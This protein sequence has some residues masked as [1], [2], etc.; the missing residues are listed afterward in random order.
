MQ[1]NNYYII[2]VLL[3]TFNIVDNDKD[4][5]PLFIKNEASEIKI[6]SS[7][8]KEIEQIGE[9]WHLAYLGKP[10]DVETVAQED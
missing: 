8:N 2:K 9:N 7:Y 3:Y 1:T 6:I 4:I 5:I 10:F